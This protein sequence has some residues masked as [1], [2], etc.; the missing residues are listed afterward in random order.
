MHTV[1]EYG[2]QLCVCVLLNAAL[3][4]HSFG[5]GYFFGYQSVMLGL[6]R[7][8][9]KCLGKKSETQ[10]NMCQSQTTVTKMFN[11]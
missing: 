1:A 2:C 8:H 7:S 9:E 11:A 3:I 6:S 10:P 4:T 5:F